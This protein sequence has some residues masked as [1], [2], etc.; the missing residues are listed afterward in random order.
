MNRDI[1]I[2]TK[3][4]KDNGYC[5]AGLDI[6]TGRWIR[7]V[8]DNKGAAI[9]AFQT[10][11]QN[12]PELCNPLYGVSADIVEEVPYKNHTEDCHINVMTMNKHGVMTL[13]EVVSLHPPF[14]YNGVIYENFSIT[15]PDYETDESMSFRIGRRYHKFIAKVFLS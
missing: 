13:A 14:E 4:R 9:L 10:H 2:L 12:T 7:L 11:Y 5:V 1:V 6:E 8:S 15:D 3:S